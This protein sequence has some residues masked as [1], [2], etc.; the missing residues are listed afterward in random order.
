MEIP[1]KRGAKARWARPCRGKKAR[2]LLAVL[3]VLMAGGAGIYWI[4][5]S[6]PSRLNDLSNGNLPVA[7]SNENPVKLSRDSDEDGLKDWEEIFYKTDPQNPD[8]DGDGTLDG[9]EIAKNRDPLKAGPDDKLAAPEETSPNGLP[10]DKMAP[11]E[12]LREA[13]EKNINLTDYFVQKVFGTAGF[14]GLQALLKPGTDQKISNEFVTF[15][16]NLSPYEPFSEKS[17]SDAEIII[18]NDSSDAAIKNYFNSVAGIYEKYVPPLQGADELQFLTMALDEES[19]EPLE[20]ITPLLDAV[21]HIAE[22]LKKL[23]V[24]RAALSLHKQELWYVQKGVEQIGLIQK[25]DPKDAVYALVVM[26]ARIK[27]RQESTKFHQ[28]TIP[29]W[30]KARGIP[31]TQDDKATLLYPLLLPQ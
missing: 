23:S 21:K 22:D 19:R 27:M 11:E 4:I 16:Q 1:P 5:Q 15:V 30:L 12:L 3:I 31:F 26:S 13:A 17:I 10:P 29:E 18:I 14:G 7:G 6:L 20:A 2:K 9:V 28:E 25:T 24:P 8:T